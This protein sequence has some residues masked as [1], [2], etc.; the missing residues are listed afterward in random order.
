MDNVKCVRHPDHAGTSSNLLVA[1]GLPTFTA[2][3]C[4]AEKK[5]DHR[6]MRN[7]RAKKG[8]KEEKDEN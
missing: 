2:H 3:C 7:L 6:P 4:L 1:A 8:E 5:F